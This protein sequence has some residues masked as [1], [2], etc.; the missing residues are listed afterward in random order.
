MADEPTP[1]VA[2]PTVRQSVSERIAR[3]I[4]SL[5]IVQWVLRKLGTSMWRRMHKAPEVQ[6]LEAL[7]AASLNSLEQGKAFVEYAMALQK[8]AEESKWSAWPPKSAQIEAMLFSAQIEAMLFQFVKGI[9]KD[10]DAPWPSKLRFAAF[11]YFLRIFG[12][13]ELMK[14]VTEKKPPE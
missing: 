11:F 7:F 2:V 10:I 1:N 4:S 5:P 13:V 14:P 9:V 6:K 12:Q 3:K 8:E